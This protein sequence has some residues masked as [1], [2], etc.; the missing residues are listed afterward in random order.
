MLATN[1][2]VGF[3]N[4]QGGYTMGKVWANPVAPDPKKVNQGNHGNLAHQL[5]SL[6]D[7]LSWIAPRDCHMARDCSLLVQG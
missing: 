5:P 7:L 1:S 4:D 3:Y 2:A 6:H